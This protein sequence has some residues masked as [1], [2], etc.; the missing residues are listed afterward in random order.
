MPDGAPPPSEPEPASETPSSDGDMP[1]QAPME[2]PPAEEQ[3]PLH[4]AAIPEPEPDMPV[5]MPPPE[6]EP[7]PTTHACDAPTDNPCLLCDQDACCEPR[8]SC[9][10]IPACA[11]HLECRSADNP[12][13]CAESC[14][15]A[16]ERYE[17]W[18]NCLSEH[19]A[20][21]CVL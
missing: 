10:E 7:L 6:G 21:Q 12:S 13:A 11:C 20:E 1:P 8:S 16:G 15:P 9:L 4:D 18:I 14:D 2:S 19:C 3:A 17:P 5:D